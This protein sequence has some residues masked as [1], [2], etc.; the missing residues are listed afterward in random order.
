MQQVYSH[1]DKYLLEAKMSP[2]QRV[3]CRA[4]KLAIA[5]L[6]AMVEAN[7]YI[8]SILPLEKV[9]VEI[10][11][12]RVTGS[13]KSA[14]AELWGEQVAQVLYDRRG[15]LGGHGAYYEIVPGDVAHLGNKTCLTFSRDQST[16]DTHRQISFECVSKLQVS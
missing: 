16:A 14:I 13:P 12:E 6:I 2:A 9:C 4:D 8:S 7:E 1:A 11:R 3:N 10:A 5:A 15:V